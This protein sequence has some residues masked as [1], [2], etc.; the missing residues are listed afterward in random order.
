[1]DTKANKAKTGGKMRD[2]F[3]PTKSRFRVRNLDTGEVSAVWGGSV[4]EVLAVIR[5]NFEVTLDPLYDPSIP[6][7]EALAMAKAEGRGREAVAG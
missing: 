2:R 6:W 5:G 3:G 7:P 1:M 4:A